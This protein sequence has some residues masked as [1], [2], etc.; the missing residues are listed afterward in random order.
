M[1]K[2]FC[3]SPPYL[4]PEIITN[5]TAT[6]LTDIYGIGIVLYEMLVGRTPYFSEN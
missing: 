5:N 3:G 2:S 6:K 1:A 4:A